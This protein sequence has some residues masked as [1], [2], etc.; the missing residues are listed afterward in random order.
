MSLRRGK[1]KR[2]TEDVGQDDDHEEVMVYTG[3]KTKHCEGVDSL[4][5]DARLRHASAERGEDVG[6]EMPAEEAEA[7]DPHREYDVVAITEHDRSRGR[8]LV[9]WKPGPDGAK[10][11]P[12]WQPLGNLK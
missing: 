6:E 7:I 2:G 12:S 9:H 5:A 11:Q 8:Y 4:P 3:K 1:R 10:Y